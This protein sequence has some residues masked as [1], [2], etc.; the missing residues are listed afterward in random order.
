M[1]T[2]ARCLE[3]LAA[4]GALAT[5]V[6]PA[7]PAA[8]EVRIDSVSSDGRSL[9]PGQLFVA[10]RGEH[11]DGHDFIR[12]AA[13]AG[14]SAALIEQA[15]L[16]RQTPAD[17]PAGLVLI[18][19]DDSRRALATLAAG[20]R[21]GFELPLI[22][23]TG[24]NGKTTVKE[25][26]AAILRAALDP[27]AGGE[28]VLATRGNLNNDIGLPLTLLGLRAHHRAAVIEM[29]MNHP[30]EI[31]ALSALAQP[32][33]AVVTNAQRAHLEGMGTVEE[34]AQEKGSIY[35]S[36]A[37]DGVAIINADDSHAGQWRAR[38]GDRQ[39]LSFGRA[40][41]ADVQ[42]LS[43]RPLGSAQ[44]IVLVTPQGELACE[45]ALLGEHNALNAAAATAA[46]L[47]AGVRLDAVRAGLSSFAGVP[48]RLQQ[49]AG[50]GGALIIDDSYNANPDSVRAAIEV[51]AA[52]PGHTWLVLGDMGEVGE[53]SAQLHDELGGLARSKGIDQLFALGEMAALAAHNFGEGGRHFK[54]ADALL[55]ALRPAL[56]ARAVVL[57]KGSR[58][59]RMEKVADALAAVHNASPAAST[60][61]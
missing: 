7:T 44:T 37:A 41:G 2:I 60:G 22:G 38:A 10:L 8:R 1:L 57:V 61:S 48:G 54:T 4:H 53:A 31:A 29:G 49:R 46:C 39:V 51:L 23:I 15:W 12:Q 27:A 45:L 59:M 17:L 26:C 42:L 28:S 56:D 14:A 32:T 35:D 11:F 30:G 21:A 47:A 6:T 36:L 3:L 16:D 34:V 33:V 55:K 25:M 58:F 43:V 5:S 18:S 40:A 20:W 19:V 9:R 52:M 13:A 24:S 50:I